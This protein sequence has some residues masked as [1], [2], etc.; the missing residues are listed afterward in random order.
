MVAK[1][2][3]STTAADAIDSLYL[4]SAPNGRDAPDE[5]EYSCETSPF[6]WHLCVHYDA[7]GELLD[8]RSDEKGKYAYAM[9]RVM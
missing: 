5:I 7:D 2:A 6:C 4:A 8:K 1:T 9:R 3:A